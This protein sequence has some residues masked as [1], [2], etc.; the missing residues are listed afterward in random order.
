MAI[1]KTNFINYSRCPR[2]VPLESIHKNR[3][4]ADISYK[5]YLEDEKKEIITEILSAMYSTDEDEEID[6]V[7]NIDEQL[8]AML[9]YYKQV[10]IEAA[11]LIKKTFGGSVI[12]AEETKEQKLFSSTINN[13][14]YLC[15]V[16]IYNET[17]ESI[18]VIEVKAATT[19]GFLNIGYSKDK[20]FHSIFA[21]VNNTLYLKE[22]LGDVG[23][24]PIKYKANRSKLFNRFNEG[25]YLYDIAVQR[26]IIEKVITNKNIKY[27]LAVLNK[28]YVFPGIYNGDEP[29]YTSDEDGNELITLID[30]T[31]L[32]E[33][34][35]S[36]IDN[37]RLKL[38]GYLL[39]KELR[40]YPLGD[41]CGYKKRTICKYFEPLCSKC[42]PKYN[43]VLNYIGGISLK[44]NDISI[45][46]LDLINAG[47]INML[48][49]PE[50]KI[51]NK[52][53]LI[54]R[55]VVR[56]SSPYIN[57]DKISTIINSLEYP[58]YHLDF[59][60]FPSPIPR[61]K[62]E[63][64]YTQS[65]FEFS[66]HIEHSPG[67]CDKDKD[68][69]IFLAKSNKDEREELVKKLLEY[70]DPNSGTLFAQKVDF[71][72]GRIKEL[73][74]IFPQYKKELMKIYNRGFDLIWILK[75]NN[76]VYKEL[77][78]DKEEAQEVNYYD[79][80]FN[81]SYS[82]KKTLPVFSNLKYD[83]LTV[84]NGTQA[85]TVY[86]NYPKMSTSEFKNYYEALREYCKQ[87]T[88]AMVVILD[89]LRKIV[90]PV[91]NK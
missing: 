69:Y 37:D 4:N 29:V 46:G 17:T 42:I 14:E 61:F 54:Q 68:N 83:N 28:D 88:W 70:I 11:K 85:V 91:S 16:D 89:S 18:N 35:Q 5:D 25:R 34:Y 65:P 19:A 79:I 15:Y 23:R 53:H 66:L 2:Y 39:A 48:D 13:I 33:E 60:T 32:T 49:I 59:E 63:K 64:P 27:Y 50:E 80:N 22:E 8:E 12:C 9:D 81:G 1:T 36:I 7:D 30:V 87:D 75:T 72:K 38:E 86:A 90:Q 10:E 43:S 71:E 62:G 52:N 74:N 51:T 31:K 47:F 41:Y 57:K 67:N 26:Y 40:D 20:E 58:I 78:F 3:L 76:E 77:G 44:D 24:D 6:L 21:K 84:K 45:R 55:N 82:I 56:G 73:A